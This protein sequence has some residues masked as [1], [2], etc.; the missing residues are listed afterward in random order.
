MPPF[1]FLVLLFASLGAFAPASVA[2]ALPGMPAIARELGVGPGFGEQGLAAFFAMLS[3]GMLIYGPLSDRWGRRPVLLAGLLLYVAASA[4]CAVADRAGLFVV[5]RAAQ[6]LGGG[7]AIVLA[8]AMVHDLF[9]P[10]QMAR[11]LSFMVPVGALVPLLSP[12]LGQ[13]LLAQS[14][15]RLIFVVQAGFGALCL[16]AVWL[17]LAESLPV[18]RRRPMRP[19]HVLTTYATILCD[20][21]VA[22]H[23]LTGSAIY[24]GMM[25]YVG[26]SPVAYMG[27]YGLDSAGYGRMFALGVCCLVAAALVNGRLVS[28]WGT[29][30]LL[31]VGTR[32]A[33]LCATATAVTGMTDAGGLPGLAA[34]LLAYM[35]CC[36]FVGSNAMADALSRCQGHAGSA[37]ALFGTVQFAMGGLANLAVGMLADGSPAP[38]GAVMAVAGILAVLGN[39]WSRPS[40][41]RLAAAGSCVKHWPDRISRP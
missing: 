16:L 23:M 1:P 30:P 34:C 7:A 38:M 33:A 15:W 25:A 17:A 2:L 6:A 27:H 36:G 9:P 8:R 37:A 35:V 13:W 20:R 26:G 18:D 28:R 3:L 40:K 41:R 39:L 29:A 32:A 24:A 19:G 22:G 10:P 4:A 14:G 12:L 31:A 5:A 21:T 11:L